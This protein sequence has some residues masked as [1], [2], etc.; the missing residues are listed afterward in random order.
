M[1][2]LWGKHKMSGVKSNQILLGDCIKLANELEDNS[3]KLVVTSPPYADAVSYGK[4]VENY[5]GSEYVGWLTELFE[6]L[7]P[8]VQENGS[9]VLNI[10]DKIKNKERQTYVF[11]LICSITKNTK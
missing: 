6:T 9:F 1:G 3:I 11:E 2:N 5:T 7:Y 8:K 10:N 4:D